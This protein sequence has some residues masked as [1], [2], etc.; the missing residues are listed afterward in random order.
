MADKKKST[1]KK[2]SKKKSTSLGTD[3]LIGKGGGKS[4]EVFI[5]RPG[6][7]LL[8]EGDYLVEVVNCEWD[9]TQ[10]QNKCLRWKLKVLD[11]EHEGATL[12][13]TTTLTEKAMWKFTEFLVA[14][15]IELEYDSGNTIT[16]DEYI[17]LECGVSVIVD[18]YKKKERNKI[19]SSWPLDTDNDDDEEEEDILAKPK[20]KRKKKKA[21]PVVEEDDEEDEEEE[22]D[23]D[24]E[25]DEEEEEDEEEDESEDDDEDEEEDDEDDGVDVDEDDI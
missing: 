8:P 16:P 9:V 1:K 10:N 6:F 21:A 7:Q 17:G 24:E 15:G 23:E 19:D 5:P 14:L 4:Q 18:T 12:L 3:L 22:E 2:S 11:G 13:H 20:K 25:S